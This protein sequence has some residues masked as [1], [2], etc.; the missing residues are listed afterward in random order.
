MQIGFVGLGKMGLN[1]VTRLVARRPHGR[2]LRP[3]RRRRGA[4]RGRRRE[5][6]VDARGARS[7]ALAA[8]RAVWVMVPVRRSH[9]VDRRRARPAA[10]GRRHDH[11]RRQHQLSRRCAARAD[12]RRPSGIDY[13]D[14]GTSGGIWGLQEGY[15]LMVGGEADVCQRLEPIFLTLAPDRRLPARRR[16]RRRPLREDDP[17]RHRVRPDAGLRRRLRAD[18]RQRVPDRSRRASPRSGC[19]AASCDRGCSS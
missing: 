19:T 15:C 1:M 9:R 7:Q 16:S 14:A 13:V 11:R 10:V 17:Q 3:Q 18:A 6:R 2:R 12:A 5:G 4:R 8:P